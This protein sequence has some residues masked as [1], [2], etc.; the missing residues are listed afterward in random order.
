LISKSDNIY[1]FKYLLFWVFIGC[2]A[3]GL[4]FYL[5]L[6]SDPPK[7]YE[8]LYAD[9]LEHLLAYAFLMGW[10]S[11]LYNSRKKQIILATAFCL[12]G[13]SL[14]YIQGWSGQR[15]FEYTDMAAN[16][17]GVFLG[18]WLSRGWCAGWL[19]WIDQALSRQ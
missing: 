10:F 4:V 12:M 2:I 8:F 3:V 14:E 19:V 16:T 9:K 1:I 13:I 6:I 5:S 11:Q 17:A 7:V 18:W 15:F